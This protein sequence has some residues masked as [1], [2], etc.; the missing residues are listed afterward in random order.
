[1]R[2]A[3]FIT[4]TVL[5]VTLAV[6]AY[7]NRNSEK[8]VAALLLGVTALIG[9]IV[10][11]ALFSSER[12]I[13]KAFSVPIVIHADTKL[14]LEGLPFPPFPSEFTIHV[15]EKLTAHPELLPDPKTEPFA[16][17]L[18]HHA[19]QRAMIY[20]LES[21]YPSSWHV[22]MFPM[23]LGETTGYAFQSKQVPSRLYLSSE[24]KVLMSGNE[25]ADVE[26]MFGHTDKFGL[27]LPKGTKL[28]VM[29]PYHDPAQGNTSKITMR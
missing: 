8:V 2:D 13:R 9:S 19:L 28:T 15:R 17:H 1:M 27:A 10:A 29:T 24:L 26:G 4:A 14:P 6:F 25:F 22:D 20:W 11:V 23:T 16:Q 12:P 18:Y 21:K 5:Y 7:F 3:L